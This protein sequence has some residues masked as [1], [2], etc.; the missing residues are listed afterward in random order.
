MNIFKES[1]CLNIYQDS[2]GLNPVFS[3]GFY[4]SG[5]KSLFKVVMRSIV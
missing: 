5:D 4:F 1:Q 2:T 3:F